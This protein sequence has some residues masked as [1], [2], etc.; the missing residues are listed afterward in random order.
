MAN[1]KITTN[2]IA[3]DAVTS[4]KLGGDLTMPGHVSLADNKELRIGTGNDLVIKHD[5]S[6][7]TLTNTTGNFT[8][9]G[10]QIYFANAANNEFPLTSSAE[11][12]PSGVAVEACPSLISL[13]E[14]KVKIDDVS[15]RTASPEPVPS[16]N[17]VSD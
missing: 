7:T 16:H 4:D 1:T 3:D 9:I 17:K 6:H 5:G 12:A 14:A 15:L 10:D 8:F 13:L 11:T 2:V